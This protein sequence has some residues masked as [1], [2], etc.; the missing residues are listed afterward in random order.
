[1]TAGNDEAKG[2]ENQLRTASPALFAL[3]CG[4]LFPQFDAHSQ[5]DPAQFIETAMG[6]LIEEELLS[7]DL[8]AGKE[9]SDSVEDD[10]PLAESLLRGEWGHMVRISF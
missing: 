9:A 10:K 3:A 6:R 5:E 8:H 2:S 4:R 1:M 7:P